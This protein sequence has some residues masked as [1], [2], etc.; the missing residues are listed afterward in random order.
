MVY[1]EFLCG[2]NEFSALKLIQHVNTFCY[3]HTFSNVSANVWL[4]CDINQL[5]LTGVWYVHDIVCSRKNW[6]RVIILAIPTLEHIHT[7]VNVSVHIFWLF[8]F[9]G[10]GN[11]IRHTLS[12]ICSLMIN[13]HLMDGPGTSLSAI[14]SAA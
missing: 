14:L 4:V 5:Q 3:L 7:H 11:K 12:N 8:N 1:L 2:Q 6:N 10:W 13:N 9:F